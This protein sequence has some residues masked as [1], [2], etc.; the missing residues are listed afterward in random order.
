MYIEIIKPQRRHISRKGRCEDAGHRTCDIT[1]G[2]ALL[3]IEGEKRDGM[4]EKTYQQTQIAYANIILS[5]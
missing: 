5:Y 1:A 2:R 3:D 4:E